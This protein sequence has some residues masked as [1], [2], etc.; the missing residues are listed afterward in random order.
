LDKVLSYLID[1]I[2]I[3]NDAGVYEYWIKYKEN[4]YIYLSKLDDNGVGTCK[5]PPKLD[6]EIFITKENLENIR[7]ELIKLLEQK[8]SEISQ[9]IDLNN[10][11]SA[12]IERKINELSNVYG[13]TK[14]TSMLVR[15]LRKMAKN[16]KI[17]GYSNMSK[18]ELIKALEEKKTKKSF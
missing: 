8:Q 17:L 12:D 7:K 6:N 10:T 5:T 2:Y 14:K 3:N 4:E 1:Q 9:D 11:F 13:G 15:D 18:K 16:K